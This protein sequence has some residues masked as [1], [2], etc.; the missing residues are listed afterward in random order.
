ML[1]AQAITNEQGEGFITRTSLRLDPLSTTFVSISYD[2]ETDK[3]RHKVS[4]KNI[5]PRQV[6]QKYSW[7][8]DMNNLL[9]GLCY[10]R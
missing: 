10:V 3:L 7:S 9:I 5:G 1:T 6:I 2:P 4:N 8:S